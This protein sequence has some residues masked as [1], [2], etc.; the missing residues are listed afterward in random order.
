MKKYIENQKGYALLIVLLFI[1]VIAIGTI[2]MYSYSVNSQ[3]FINASS[4]SVQDKLKADRIMDEAIA[5][6]QTGIDDI[7]KKIASDYPIIA[8]INDLITRVNNASGGKYNIV[9]T[10]TAN[11]ENQGLYNVNATFTVGVNSRK[12]LVKTIALSTV[13]DIFR[14]ST[15][16]NGDLILNGSSYLEGD[17]YTNGSVKS[18]NYGKFTSTSCTRYGACGTVNNYV[19]T[20]FPAI[21]GTLT[22]K[23]SLY[24]GTVS[25]S[26]TSWGPQL[27]VNNANLASTFSL[28]PKLKE[29]NLNFNPL[30]VSS[31]ISAKSSYLDPKNTYTY[32]G[33]QSYSSKE[34]LTGNLRYSNLTIG[35]GADLTVKGNLIVSNLNINSGGKLTVNGNIYVSGS[36]SLSG[37]LNLNATNSYIYIQDS[38]TIFNFT[39]YGQM[40]VNNKVDITDDFNTNGTLYANTSIDV[41]N[42]SNNSGGTL[43]LICAG[44]INVVNNNTYNDVPKEMNAYFYSNN[45][46]EI[47]GT[48]SNLKIIGGIYGNPI[49]LNATKG[50][51]KQSS[52]S[53]SFNVGNIYFEN[54]QLTLEPT[55][56]RLSVIYKKE[57]IYNPPNGIP[58]IDKINIKEIE[59]HYTK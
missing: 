1:T 45:K 38:A 19:P 40:Y 5:K 51:A 3:K 10:V 29:R 21:N 34:S 57:L 24:R 11:G 50:R 20:S 31:L 8:N 54:N 35:N 49:E 6:V 48:F 36:A 2:T 46:L 15:V 41:T 32:K 59:T 26:S 44:T 47:Y 30:P 28:V 23:G 42:L 53:N 25:G 17:V 55:K 22:V 9:S 18:L 13:Q 39:L 7:N 4:T 16:S 37:I 58:T 33:G 27:A 14:Y 52:F 56:S 12:N 43:I